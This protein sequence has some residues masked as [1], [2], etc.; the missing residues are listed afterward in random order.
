MSKPDKQRVGLQRKVSSVFQGVT[1]PGAKHTG[2]SSPVSNSDSNGVT[3]PN[4]IMEKDHIPGVR[5]RDD[6]PQ[7]IS[8]EPETAQAAAPEGHS[9]NEKATN[10][11]S[12]ETTDKS[13]PPAPEPEGPQ[14]AQSSLMKKL[15]QTEG[16]NDTSISS[17]SDSA[18]PE[19]QKTPVN[20]KTIPAKE[21]HPAKQVPKSKPMSQSSL[22]K[23]LAQSDE[24]ANETVSDNKA[25]V[26]VPKAPKREPSFNRKLK[27]DGKAE[28][29]PVSTAQK[30]HPLADQLAK[31]ADEG[32]FLRQI[33]EKLIPSEEEGGSTKDKVM[34][35]LVPILAIVMVFAF[36]NVLQQ[37]PS[38][39]S[40]S[41]KKDEKVVAAAKSS[42]EIEWKIPEPL[43]VMTRDPLQLP[44]NN[45][46][47][48]SDRAAD[49][50]D[51]EQ[52]TA[53]TAVKIRDGV[54][55]V[56]DVVYSEEKASALVGDRIVYAGSKIDDVTIVKINRDSVEFESN[57]EVWIQRV[58]D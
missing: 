41:N 28:A 55:N 20:E 26:I 23:R 13:V 17:P 22:M 34:V 5:P 43:P 21:E 57:G 24:P 7:A 3:P 18:E 37:S 31:A 14:L 51:T 27:N 36:R 32:G 56:R 11:V 35:M 48:N 8:P 4:E 30:K 39:A 9:P 47:E 33:K 45:E 16:P 38:K 25:D 12:P 49:P 58:R 6:S 10:D 52:K 44:E 54:I 2:E 1:V 53:T 42:D 40:A 19:V 50:T 15:T 46:T 29:S